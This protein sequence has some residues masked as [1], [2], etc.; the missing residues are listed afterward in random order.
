[1][2]TY[3]HSY[4]LKICLLNIYVYWMLRS[5]YFLSLP[6][7][8]HIIR[9]LYVRMYFFAQ[10]KHLKL[11]HFIKESWQ[12]AA[13]EMTGSYSLENPNKCG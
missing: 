6:L 13:I 12:Q 10:S 11:G 1:M 7:H 5:E 9:C 3:V 8:L 2:L 4:T